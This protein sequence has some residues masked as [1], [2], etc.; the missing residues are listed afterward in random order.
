[1]RRGNFVSL[2]APVQESLVATAQSIR[3]QWRE[4]VLFVD[5]CPAELYDTACRALSQTAGVGVDSLRRRV[6]AILHAHSLGYSN[7]EIIERGQE[8]AMSEFL[9]AKKQEKYGQT[10]RMQFEVP[11]FLR[12]LIQQDFQRIKTACGFSTSEDLFDFLHSVLENTT[13]DQ[14]RELAKGGKESI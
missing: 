1:M 12:E 7:E 14:F 10:V 13:D 5:R 3:N 4:I 8:K 6:S 11:G 2:S 9:T